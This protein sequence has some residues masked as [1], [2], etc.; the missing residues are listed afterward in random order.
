MTV[1]TCIT[2]QVKDH[3]SKLSGQTKQK[4]DGFS[5]IK[6][7]EAFKYTFENSQGNKVSCGVIY[8][9]YAFKAGNNDAVGQYT[10][11]LSKDQNIY[12]FPISQRS[13]VSKKSDYKQ[14]I[15]NSRT[16]TSVHDETLN[17]LIFPAEMIKKSTRINQSGKQILKIVL[18]EESK[19]YFSEQRK[20]LVE[21]LY[22]ELSD[23]KVEISFGQQPDYILFSKRARKIQ[24]RQDNKKRENVKRKEVVKK[25]DV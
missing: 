16:L 24:K 22:K 17:D 5:K 20:E 11:Q 23:R 21:L 15:P 25:T 1:K 12:F 6:I 3:L 14:K 2:Q 13:I 7:T 4:K 10:N 8:I 9:P 19:E 18:E